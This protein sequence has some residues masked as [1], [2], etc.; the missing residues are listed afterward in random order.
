MGTHDGVH[1]LPG[2]LAFFADQWIGE[3]CGY[4]LLDVEAI[5]LIA[6]ADLSGHSKKN[7]K[8]KVKR[9]KKTAQ[10]TRYFSNNARS[11]ALIARQVAMQENTDVMAILFRDADGT[12]SS[13]RG[14]WTTKHQSM[15]A[16][17]AAEGF[18]QGIPMLPKPISEAWLL[19]AVQQ[20][21]QHCDQLENAS[22][23]N[24]S[25]DSLKQ[26]LASLMGGETT[27]SVLVDAVQDGL[28]DM[29]KITMPSM[30]AFKERADHVLDRLG[31]P[32]R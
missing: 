12:A 13:S 26:R 17:F 4:S 28:I 10:V 5:R 25:P 29:R 14:E 20:Q 32:A 18:D 3:R 1:F 7:L 21:Y 6:K 9:G 31:F 8:P 23:R 27:Q 16:G 22:G 15:L 11:L 24:G 19:C 30:T 2:P